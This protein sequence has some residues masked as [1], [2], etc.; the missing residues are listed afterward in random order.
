MPALGWLMNLGFAGGGVELP[1]LTVSPVRRPSLDDT[2]PVR[3]STVSTT[4]IRRGSPA[5]VSPLRRPSDN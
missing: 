2:D 4:P 3:R 1:S 5:V